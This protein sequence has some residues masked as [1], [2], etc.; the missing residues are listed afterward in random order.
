MLLGGAGAPA[1]EEHQ[2]AKNKHGV[3]A[4]GLNKPARSEQDTRTDLQFT[5]DTCNSHNTLITLACT[6]AT[7]EDA[8]STS[9]TLP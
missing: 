3:D 1:C 2:V 7:E 5:R 8:I 9:S 6:T 4:S